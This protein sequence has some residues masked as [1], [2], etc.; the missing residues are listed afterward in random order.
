MII[1]RP[2]SVDLS[3]IDPTAPEHQGHPSE[4]QPGAGH[5]HGGHGLMMMACC[6]PM[7]VI[8]VSLVATGAAGSGLIVTV[9][10]CTAMMAAM[11]FAMPGAHGHK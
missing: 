10:L 8:A 2:D 11:M 5:R 1:Q 3:A 7:I 9:L 6:V 4:H